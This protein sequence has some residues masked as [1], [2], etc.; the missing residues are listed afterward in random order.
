LR[1]QESQQECLRVHSRASIDAVSTVMLRPAREVDADAIAGVWHAAWHDAHDAHVPANLIADRPLAYFVGSVP[2]V[3]ARTTV[4]E[5]ETGIIGFVTV[6]D[7]E[8][9]LLFVAA[10]ARGTGVAAALLERGETHIAARFE[11]AWLDVV[12]GN[13]RARRFYARMGWVEEGSRE[14]VAQT[15]AGPATVV[16]RRYEKWL[17]K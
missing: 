5:D 2:R 6:T 12:A 10:R 14:W 13:A 1:A 3:V 11:Q 16:Y 8:L 9:D 17:R 4:A 7:D 15:S